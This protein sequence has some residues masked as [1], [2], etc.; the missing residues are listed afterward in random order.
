VIAV[1]PGPLPPGLDRAQLLD[2][3]TAGLRSLAHG[4]RAVV[5]LSG[6]PDSTAAAYLAAEARPD[7]VLML[8]HVRHG[9]RDDVEDV[10]LVRQHAA[11]LGLPLEIRTVEVVP[12]GHGPE[13]AARD[14]RYAALRD[15]AHDHEAR[16]IVVA[17]TAED[18]AETLLLRLAR[19]TGVAGLRG[20]ATH[21]RDLV[22]PLLRVRRADLRRFLDLEG[23]PAAADPTNRDPALRRVRARSE[24]LPALERLGPDPVGALGRLAVLAAEDET[25][26]SEEAEAV[27][28]TSLVRTG[29]VRS[30]RD[31]DLSAVPAAVRH[32]V[33][34][35]AV[36]EVAEAPPPTAAEV[37]TIESLTAGQRVQL[38]GGVEVAA[39]G[40]WRTVAPR[41]VQMA[42]VTPVEVP[43]CTP[44]PPAG[45]VVAAETPDVSAEPP[46]GQIA[47]EMSGAWT[48]R[49]PSRAEVVAPPG[50]W[51]DRAHLALPGDAGPWRLR[52]RR[53]GDRIHTR[54]G[55]AKVADVLVD[56]GVPYAVRARWPLLVDAD[57]R[58][59]WVPGVAVDRDVLAAGRAEPGVLLVVGTA[60]DV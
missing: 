34:R 44:W 23:L 6:G 32:R 18:Q 3:V 37:A 52:H 41:D 55:T 39:G 28:A 8:G 10:A 53:P 2:A 59:V 30:L 51:H 50:G 1:A 31:H 14:A 25:A 36:R 16:A 17:H 57:D 38:P 48:P 58:V 29:S 9:L 40:G 11:F 20:M 46:P 56:A 54:V 15:V 7:L 26:L 60:P 21:D 12:T 13:A 22:R 49:R 5:A 42:P 19:G 43:G 45:V 24:V 35:R 4:A 33:W 27:L 47:L